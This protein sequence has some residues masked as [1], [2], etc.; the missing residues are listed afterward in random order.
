MGTEHGKFLTVLDQ[1]RAN[2]ILI[3]IKRFPAARHIKTAILGM[4]YSYF[5]K[6]IVEVSCRG[7]G[8]R[9][10]RGKGYWFPNIIVYLTA[11]EDFGYCAL[12]PC[13]LSLSL[14]TADQSDAD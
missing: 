6:E 5:N 4:D 3:E 7:R 11:D 10:S 2:N 14:E 8:G 9:L 12:H 13:S 1:R